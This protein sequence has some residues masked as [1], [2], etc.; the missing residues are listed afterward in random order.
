MITKATLRKIYQEAVAL[1]KY[2]TP[3]LKHALKT[4]DRV[5]VFID[6]L[7]GELFKTADYLH[8]KG[9]TLDEHKLKL[10][11]YDMVDVFLTQ[12]EAN[13]RKR[14]ESDMARIARETLQDMQQ[15]PDKHLKEME[16][17]TNDQSN[18]RQANEVSS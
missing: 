13:A 15:N 16:V 2:A 7:Y 9:M 18:T 3:E 14:Y 17:M 10:L 12:F 4:S 6:N 5:P 11:V 8:T 1:S